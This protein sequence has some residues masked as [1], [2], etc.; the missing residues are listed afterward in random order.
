MHGNH[1]F[2]VWCSKPFCLDTEAQH[3]IR[4]KMWGAIR[5]L[6]LSILSSNNRKCCIN[7]SVSGVDFGC[8][9]E[10]PFCVG[11]EDSLTPL[12][13]GGTGQ[14]CAPCL[15]TDHGAVDDGCTD[16]LPRCA[17]ADGT[18]AVFA[19][20]TCI[21]DKVFANEKCPKEQACTFDVKIC[22]DGSEVGR[23]PCNNCEFFTCPD[24]DTQ[25]T[26]DVSECPDGSFVS[27][28]PCNNCEFFPCPSCDNQCTFDVFECP[29][30][31]YVSRDPCNDC[32]F[33]PCPCQEQCTDDV[34]V[35]EDGKE[36]SRDPCTCEFPPC[37]C[38][39]PKLEPGTND[40][41]FCFEGHVCCPDGTWSCGIGDG[42]FSCGGEIVKESKG[43]VCTSPC[44]GDCPKDL[45]VCD[46]GTQLGRD[47]CTCEFPKC[48]KCEQMCTL[49]AKVCPDGSTVGRDPC[50]A[51][52]FYPCPSPCDGEC[53]P[54]YLFCPNG[55]LLK[56]DPCIGCEFNSCEP[57]PCD[58]VCLDNDGN[59]QDDLQLCPDGKTWVPRDPCNG[60][61]F[62]ECTEDPCNQQC[63]TDMKECPDGSFVG[64]DPCNDC[65]FDKCPECERMCPFDV[66]TCPDGSFVSRDPCNGCAFAPCL[67]EGAECDIQTCPEDIRNDVLLC[68]DGSVST[69]DP[70]NKKCDFHVCPPGFCKRLCLDDD[71]KEC[72][73]GT[74][75]VARDP[76]NGCDHMPC[77]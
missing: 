40:N 30:G 74:T 7:L 16:A 8:R 15:K 22:G 53:K 66:F 60:C 27:R 11:P 19:G 59:P 23:D 38:C 4:Q 71:V 37:S 54:E 26:F 34:Y 2:V 52:E 12:P 20:E 47:P 18:V 33:R 70:C 61:E 43:K 1:F 63:L 17:S 64:R 10:A 48:P 50:N 49:D 36:L 29:D 45:L 69:R 67:D 57:H 75:Y 51:C 9:T 24:C 39:D 72:P 3:N 31:S 28:D 76:C 62:V 65:E 41:P 56:R 5:C 32:E 42:T 44:I 14:R 6:S 46:D 25:C 77:P 58:A 21:A 68:A 55:N 13:F 35:C 73:D